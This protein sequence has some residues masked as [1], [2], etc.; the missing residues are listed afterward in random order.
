MATINTVNF[1]DLFD[2]SPEPLEVHDQQQEQQEQQ[3]Q[4]G[5][6]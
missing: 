5:P 4:N 3:V 2:F 6:N 1:E